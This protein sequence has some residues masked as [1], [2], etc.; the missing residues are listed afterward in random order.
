MSLGEQ[1]SAS[2]SPAAA[3]RLN[4]MREEIKSAVPM[5]RSIL[6]AVREGQSPQE[7]WHNWGHEILKPEPH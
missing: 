3:N 1:R 4:A 7:L 2:T 6:S 5:K